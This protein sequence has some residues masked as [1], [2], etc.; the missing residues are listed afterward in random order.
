MSGTH[1]TGSTNLCRKG[2]ISWETYVL[3]PYRPADIF[4]DGQR[5]A[6]NGEFDAIAYINTIGGDR[7]AIADVFGAK[8]PRDGFV[9]RPQK[10]LVDRAALQD[11]TGIEQKNLIRQQRGLDGVA[12]YQDR[13]RV[14]FLLQFTQV[15]AD[16]GLQRR[17]AGGE[18]F[19]KELKR[20]LARQR[21]RQRDAL[22]PSERQFSEAAM[23]QSRKAKP[24]RP[25]ARH[26]G[27]ATDRKAD[28]F[29]HRQVRKETVGLRHVG[30]PA[31]RVEI[32]SR[33]HI[34]PSAR[35]LVPRSRGPHQSE[36]H[37]FPRSGGTEDGETPGVRSPRDIEFEPGQM[38]PKP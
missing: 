17:V 7:V 25:M 1:I 35:L 15:P 31:G 34:H 14:D 36:R 33:D 16:I 27:I 30:N 12:G 8:Q 32:G 6:R 37:G 18:R 4:A 26:V 21:T 20:C 5:W 24:R 2:C 10:Y 11:V 23:F 13:R 3:G 22:L 29:P 38:P 28:L 9:G 19:I